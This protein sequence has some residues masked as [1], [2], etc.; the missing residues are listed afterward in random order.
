MLVMRD[1]RSGATRS[2]IVPNKGATPA[3]IPEVS[4]QWIESLGYGTI[5]LKTNQEP[6]I[7]AWAEAVKRHRNARMAET[8]LEH[9]AVRESQSNGVAE[10]AIGEVKGMVR[11]MKDALEVRLQ[12]H[13]RRHELILTWLVNHAG[14][15]ITRHKVHHDGRT[16]YER[17]KG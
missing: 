17:L 11:T 16:S 3:W 14:T 12:H 1:Q 15:L 6:S 9:S 13:C 8:I 4:A 5:I 7:V 10:R 2:M